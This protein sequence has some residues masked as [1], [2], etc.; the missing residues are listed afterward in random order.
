MMP[1]FSPE[2][3]NSL[4]E[5]HL[6]DFRDLPS[7]VSQGGQDHRHGSNQKAITVLCK[8]EHNGL[9]APTKVL[10][11][12]QWPMMTITS[13]PTLIAPNHLNKPQT[14]SRRPPMN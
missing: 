6:Q 3:T 13:H 4:K 5:L 2:K 11:E 12:D 8:L 1:F 9:L 7:E 10:L 14:V